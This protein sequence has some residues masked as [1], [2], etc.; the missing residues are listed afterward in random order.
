MNEETT[1]TEGVQALKN[2][3]RANAEKILR[4][5]YATEFKAL[6][7]AEATKLGVEYTFRKTKEEKAREQ[8][9][10]LIAEFPDLVKE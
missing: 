9:E 6:V 5:K 8:Y 3:A 10:A 7:A 4:E 1:T 2:K